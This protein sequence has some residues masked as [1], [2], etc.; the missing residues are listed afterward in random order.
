MYPDLYGRLRH[1]GNVCRFDNGQPF[2]LDV[3]NRQALAFW[4]QV[5]H[6]QHIPARIGRLR[7]RCGEQLARVVERIV[8]RLATGSAAE[9]IDEFVFCDR[10]NP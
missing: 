3:L 4:Q 1:T 10:M 7:I 9:E 5:E 8:E 6:L 2:D